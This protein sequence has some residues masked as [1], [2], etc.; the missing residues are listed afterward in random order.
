[1]QAV[2]LS[3][4]RSAFCY[5]QMLT[6]DFLPGRPPVSAR[7]HDVINIHGPLKGCDLSPSSHDT[8]ASCR[9]ICFSMALHQG[10]IR[11]K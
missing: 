7:E 6:M 5:G 10:Y 9:V 3:F 8:V 2:T 4:R 1:M 11:C